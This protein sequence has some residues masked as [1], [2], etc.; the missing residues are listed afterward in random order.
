[1]RKIISLVIF[2]LILVSYSCEKDELTEPT[3][4]DLE[5]SMDSYTDYGQNGPK[6]GSSFE[7]NE[8]VMI[9]E[10][11][12]FDGRRDEGEDYYFTSDFSEPLIAEL[13]N[14]YTNQNVAYDIPQGIYNRIELNFSIGDGNENALCLQGQYQRGPLDDVEIRFEYA[15]KEQIRIRAQN[16][17]NNEQIVLKSNSDIKANVIFDA[18]H[19][20]KIVSMN[21]I[22][23]AETTQ[24]DGKNLILINNENN[25]D[26]F[27]VL[28]T[29]LDN[30]IRVI[31]DE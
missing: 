24:E 4:V 19:L 11:I 16:N 18:P 25:I 28:V 31:F 14:K 7:I 6:S 22:K 27:N 20:F 12:E 5:F 29:R 21:M 8:G 2:S 9:I 15:F 23:N 13:H 1:M 3:K 26:I 30:S 10:S 17:M